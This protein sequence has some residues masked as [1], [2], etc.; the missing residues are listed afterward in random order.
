MTG[1]RFSRRTLAGGGFALVVALIVGVSLVPDLRSGGSASPAA[2]KRIERKND[3][4]ATEAAAQMR[5]ESQV[6]T[7]AAE[8]LRAAQER[9]RAEADAT[10]ARFDNE[11]AGAN[12]SAPAGGQ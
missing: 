3:R 10:L 7:R 1:R 9:G 6:S 2:L 5:S 8:S 4:A 12:R 11:A